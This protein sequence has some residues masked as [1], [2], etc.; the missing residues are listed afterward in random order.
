M[1]I[2]RSLVC[3]ENI[4]KKTSVFVLRDDFSSQFL[5][6]LLNQNSMQIDFRGIYRKIFVIPKMEV[7]IELF[8]W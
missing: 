3:R 5:N 4:K 8:F 6:N 7:M 1:Y 2:S